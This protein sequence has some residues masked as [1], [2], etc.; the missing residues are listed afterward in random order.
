[1]THSFSNYL[2]EDGPL[3]EPFLEPAIPPP[4]P[5]LQRMT[6]QTEES[7]EIDPPEV[8]ETQASEERILAKLASPPLVIEEWVE[9]MSSRRS[10][11]TNRRAMML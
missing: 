11:I 4:E 10:S 9:A 5:C 8:V 1:M 6:G 7:L 3:A 2:A